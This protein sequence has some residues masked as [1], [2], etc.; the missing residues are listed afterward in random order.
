MFDRLPLIVGGRSLSARVACRTAE[1][2]D[3]V[4]VLCL[5]LPLR[6]PSRGS[7]SPAPSVDARASLRL[8]RERD[9]HPTLTWRESRCYRNFVN[10]PGRIRTSDRGLEVDARGVAAA[11]DP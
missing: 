6:P 1:A 11:R 7:A 5:A 10:P 4:G 3:A 2:S 8:A 9:A